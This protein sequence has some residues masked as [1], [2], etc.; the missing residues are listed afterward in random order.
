LVQTDI[1]NPTA[2]LDQLRKTM[3]SNALSPVEDELKRLKKEI[4]SFLPLETESSKNIA[5]HVFSGQGKYIRPA[6]FFLS[7]RLCGYRGDHLIPIGAVCE[8]VHTASLLHDDV[9]DHSDLRRNKPTANK[10]WGDQAAVLVGDLV[11]SRASE[12][13]A[14]TGQMDLVS[15]FARSI[16]K[17]SEGEL[18]Q[19]ENVFNLDFP[20]ETYLKLLNCKTGVLIGAACRAGGILAG[21]SPERRFALEEFG[22]SLGIAFQLIDDALDYI[23]N[24]E[25]FGKPTQ[26]DLLEGKVTL[27]IIYLRDQVT[28]DEKKML[29]KILDQPK[30]QSADVAIVSELVEKYQTAKQTMD[31]AGTFTDSALSQLRENFPESI[32]RTQIESL[33]TSLL[34]RLN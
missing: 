8:Y 23:G 17:M 25:L 31:R 18:L 19:L 24:R 14:S 6:L 29:Q 32:E 9:V 22:R 2:P 30:I 33:A 20:E 4:T 10:I 16:R 34:L 26:S 15:T 27:P 11:Y 1:A 7:A 5:D 12:L 13:M 3:L 28:K 21:V